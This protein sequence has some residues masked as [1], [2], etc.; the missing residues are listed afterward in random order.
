MVHDYFL[1]D[2]AIV[3]DTIENYLPQLEALLD[4]VVVDN[5]VGEDGSGGD[6]A[7]GAPPKQ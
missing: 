4:T 1:I 6:M 7:R 2:A 5:D 3:W